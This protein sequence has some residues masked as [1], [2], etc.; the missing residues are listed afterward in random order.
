MATK[1]E[2][3]AELAALKSEM[4][5]QKEEPASKTQTDS[6]SEISPEDPE[7]NG[8]HQLLTEHGIDTENIES[9]GAKLSEELVALQKDKPLVVLI[10]AFA[11]GC[12]VGRTFK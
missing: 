6:P 10:A 7:I 2:L 4:A 11:L 12:I 9:L 8:L 1:A 5:Q 3:E